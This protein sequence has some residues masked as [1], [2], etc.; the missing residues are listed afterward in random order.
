MTH[1]SG[2][3][4]YEFK[5]AFNEDLSDQPDKTW[6]PEELLSYVLDEVPS[7]SAGEGWEYSDTNF[8]LLGMI[9]EEVTGE[10]DDDEGGALEEQRELVSVGHECV[11]G[12]G[13]GSAVTSA[14]SVSVT[15]CSSAGTRLA[16][17][18]AKGLAWATVISTG[19]P[20]FSSIPR[21][22]RRWSS[23]WLGR[24]GG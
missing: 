3:M 8:I 23:S 9:I 10:P 7:F 11:R 24:T 4:R 17:R 20:A 5:P 12:R 21:C 18:R 13:A 19:V 14:S 22:R 16:S 15:T 6:R 1:T 2:V